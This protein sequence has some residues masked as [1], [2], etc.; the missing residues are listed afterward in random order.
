M[1][2]T[3]FIITLVAIVENIEYYNDIFI[4]CLGLAFLIKKTSNIILLIDFLFI[5]KNK[6]NMFKY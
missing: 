6:D 2:I 5:L 1:S 4:E 3:C